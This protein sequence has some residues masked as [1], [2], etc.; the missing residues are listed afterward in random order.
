MGL[1]KND[2]KS[3]SMGT[4]LYCNLSGGVALIVWFTTNGMCL[5]NNT[6]I[7]V[8]GASNNKRDCDPWSLLLL[9]A[10]V[11]SFTHLPLKLSDC[12]VH[13]RVSCLLSAHLKSW[14]FLHVFISLLQRRFCT[15]MSQ[16][17]GALSRCFARF[18]ALPFVPTN[19]YFV[20]VVITFCFVFYLTNPCDVDREFE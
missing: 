17:D 11:W 6:I 1:T 12:N 9:A 7:Y 3:K 15:T 10:A 13:H 16:C 20:I 5:K 4:W 2:G 19:T 8:P 14:Y 18:S